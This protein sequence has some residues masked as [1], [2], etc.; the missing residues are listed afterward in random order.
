M[1]EGKYVPKE[2]GKVPGPSNPPKRPPSLR[3]VGRGVLPFEGSGFGYMHGHGTV[4]K[5]DGP[6]YCDTDE[7]CTPENA[8]PCAR[9]GLDP[10]DYDDNDPCLHNLPGVRN[11]CCGHGNQQAFIQ[12][13]NGILIQGEFEVCN[14]PAARRHKAGVTSND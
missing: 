11:A 6:Y 2:R 7:K 10:K 9:C 5:D 13:E 3:R 12:F 1:D 8:R 14:G 4:I